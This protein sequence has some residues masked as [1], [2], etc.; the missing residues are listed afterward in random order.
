L[1]RNGRIE[2]E[3]GSTPE[4]NSS[5]NRRGGDYVMHMMMMGG[6]FWLKDEEVEEWRQ[7]KKYEASGGMMRLT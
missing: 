1:G 6:P 3:K 2:A 7:G 5:S 4:Q